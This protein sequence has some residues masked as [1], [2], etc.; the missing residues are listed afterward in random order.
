MFGLGLEPGGETPGKFS[1]T[2]RSL[3][4]YFA[5]RERAG[6]FR[7]PFKQSE[8]QLTWDQQVAVS[9]LIGTDWT[10]PQQ[11]QV[12]RQREKSLAELKRAGNEGTLGPVLGSA[13]ELRTELALL[14]DR[15]RQQREVTDQF[16]VLPQYRQLEAEASGLARQIAGLSNDNVLDKQLVEQLEA[17]TAAE[18]PPTHQDVERLYEDMGISL[19]DLTV[20]RYSEVRDFHDSVIEN[21]SL[22]L[23]G[24]VEAANARIRQREAQKA[25]M[26]GRRQQI[27]VMLN[28]RGALDQFV[29][30]QAE[31]SRIEADGE[32][33]RRRLEAAEQIEGDKTQLE[34]ER[35]ALFLRLQ[36]D[37]REQGGKLTAA[38]TAFEE[39][40]SSLYEDAGS[41]VIEEAE[42]GPSFAVSVFG[43]RSRGI[44]NMQIYCF[45]MMLMRVWAERGS[46]P[47]FLIHDSHLF[48]GV[49]ERQIAR[50]LVYGAAA[51]KEHGF[52]YI[53]TINSDDLPSA[54]PG[55]FDVDEHTLAVT[56]TDETEQGGLFGVR[57]E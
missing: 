10:I 5:R 34:L 35:N 51:A 32:V 14:E 44:S 18:A 6:G 11:L 7:R 38:I 13:G 54:Y 41:L 55:G 50:A 47:G 43:D 37:Y 20:R 52:Q 2:F 56:L 19:P 17:S 40:S 23:S 9:F 15:A 1:P 42:T 3:F 39:V 25:R 4:S 24:E 28:T 31:L 36:Q 16:Q 8:Q 53:V 21:R 57:F 12:L 22:Y 45:D 30:L 33:T 46:G 27:M 26:D 48:D 49:D 29:G